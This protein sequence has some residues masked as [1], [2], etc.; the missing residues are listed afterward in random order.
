MMAEVDDPRVEADERTGHRFDVR[1]LEPSPPAV[2][3]EPWLADDPVHRPGPS[4]G[5]VLAPVAGLGSTWDELAQD[6]EELA[7][8]CADRWLGAWRRL[9]PVPAAY[10]VHR[11]RLHRV[12]EELAEARRL[13]TGKIGLRW[14]RGGFGTPWFGPGEGEQR[15]AEDPF[16]GDLFGFGASVLEALRV[17]WSVDDTRVQLWPEHFDLSIDCGTNRATYG[18]SPG[19]DEHADPYLYVAPWARQTGSFWSDPHFGGAALA[20]D[21]LLAG[22]DQRAA[23]LAFFTTGWDVLHR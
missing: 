19:D 23:A 5:D 15:R 10:D 13:A 2:T 12:A 22:E 21:D 20:Y 1:V 11:A 3:A 6:D 16:L 17:T 4:A 7:T 9:E 14:V 18:V 8:W